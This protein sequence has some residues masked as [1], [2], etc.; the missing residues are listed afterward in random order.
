M[1]QRYAYRVARDML[2]AKDFDL[3]EES[4]DDQNAIHLTVRRMA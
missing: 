1:A 2:A 3:V 4:L